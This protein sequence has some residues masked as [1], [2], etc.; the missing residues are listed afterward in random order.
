MV[1]IVVGLMR[2][3]TSLVSAQLHKLGIPMGTSMRFPIPGERGQI[4]YED[5]EL[6][7]CCLAALKGDIRKAR[8][9]L[10][11]NRYIKDRSKNNEIWGVKSP[12][13]LPYVE[14]FKE[15]SPHPVK[16]I[17]T[18]RNVDDTFESIQRQTSSSD[19]IQIQKLLMTYPEPLVDLVVNIEESWSNPELVKQKLIELING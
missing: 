7:D 10:F 8:L 18:R 15:E 17:L 13:L 2:T 1:V 12:F 16:V 3:G 14:M 9:R 4:D 6:T 19:P 11:F 5:I